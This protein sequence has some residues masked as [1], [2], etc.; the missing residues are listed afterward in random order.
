MSGSQ[1]TKISLLFPALG[2]VFMGAGIFVSYG[3]ID[4]LILNPRGKLLLDWN[5]Y[6]PMAIVTSLLFLVPSIYL[7]FKTFKSRS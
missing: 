3:W 2:F 5:H 1:S 7:F 6:V 4:V